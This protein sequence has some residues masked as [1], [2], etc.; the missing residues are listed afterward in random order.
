MNNFTIKHKL[1]ALAIAVTFFLM[2]LFAIT[3]NVSSEIKELNQA[4]I[5]VQTSEIEVLTLRRNEKDF[6]A[7][8]DIKYLQ[9][10]EQNFVKLI[11]HI[12]KIQSKL[13]SIG[14]DNDESH[15]K[16]IQ[17]LGEYKEDFI[18][19]VDT[20]QQIGL[21]HEKG[22]RGRL[23]SSVHKA[24]K[25]LTQSNSL[26]LISDMLILRRNE[27]DFML[28]K[29]NKY[30]DKFEKNFIIFSKNLADSSFDTVVKQDILVK[31]NAYRAMFNELK[32]SYQKLGLTPKEGLQG[33]MRSTVHKTEGIIQALDTRLS[34]Q[35]IK[36]NKNI[37][38]N[39][40]YITGIFIMLIVTSILSMSRS[41]N[42]RLWH[43]KHHLSDVSLK[44]GDLSVAIKTTGKDEI[45]VISQLFNQFIA[46]LRKTFIEIPSLSEHLNSVSRENSIV[47]QKTNHLAVKQ[48]SESEQLV[49]SIQQMLSFTSNITRNIHIAANLASETNESVLTGKETIKDISDS[50]HSL[51]N[52]LQLSVKIT[53]KLE[54]SSND[55]REVLDVIRAIAEQTNLLALNAAIEAARAGENGRGFAVVAGEV[56][57]LAKRTQDSTMQIETLVESFQLDVKN[58]SEAMK[59]G[60]NEATNTARK[61][62]EANET[63]D[64]ISSS[65]DQMF[66]LNSNIATFSEEQ[67]IISSG[68]KTNTEQIN[69]M[70]QETSQQASKTNE[71]SSQIENIASDFQLLLATYRL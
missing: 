65:V 39:L 2:A 10:F 17:Q 22:L 33:E 26:Q 55:I 69:Q 63:L 36:K 52:K 28:R 58:T 37:N 27:K 21:N 68:I 48:Q 62:F 57:A 38:D 20:H 19:I 25:H 51:A 61:S 40:L 32:F 50:V 6:L 64:V 59:E 5:L 49:E 11:A 53:K 8:L 47:S 18:Q 16:L 1:N 43:L 66:E 60:A 44:S 12:N 70:A 23:R 42:K 4:L 7:R 15:I 31:M 29:D 71:S 30:I 14:L 35:I 56:R 41:I 13:E 45:T 54:K 46:N 24:E 9:K 67:E 34:K 3:L